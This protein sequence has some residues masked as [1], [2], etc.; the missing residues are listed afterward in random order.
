[1]DVDYGVIAKVRSHEVT[2]AEPI[3]NWQR[4]GRGNPVYYPNNNLIDSIPAAQIIGGIAGA[5]I[6]ALIAKKRPE[7]IT[8]FISIP[9]GASTGAMIGKVLSSI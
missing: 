3:H 6:F 5:V 4:I 8:Q 9:V 2:K 1:M 7:F